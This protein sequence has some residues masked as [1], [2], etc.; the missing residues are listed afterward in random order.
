MLNKK[1]PFH[2]SFLGSCFGII[3]KETRRN[4]GRNERT[5]G[6]TKQT[7]TKVTFSNK[8]F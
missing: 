1:L 8:T 6:G 7:P 2:F 3:A 5:N 4:D